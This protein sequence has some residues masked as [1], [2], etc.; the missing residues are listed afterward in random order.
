MPKNIYEIKNNNKYKYEIQLLASC[1]SELNLITIELQNYSYNIKTKLINRDIYFNYFNTLGDEYLITGLKGVFVLNEDKNYHRVNKVLETNYINGI[2]ITEKIFAFISN[3]LLPKGEN[4]LLIY[5]FKKNGTIKEINNYPFKI[6]NNSLYS[7]N[8][9]TINSIDI[10]RK[11]LFSSCVSTDKNGFLFVD[12][13]LK[14]NTF[15]ESFYE[16]K[17]FEPNCFCQISIVDNNN[18]INDD[19]AKEKN[20]EIKETEY[21]LVGGFEPIKRM[22]SVKLYKIKY[23]SKNDKINIRYLFDIATEDVDQFKG[24]NTDVTC[25]TQSKITGNLLI[26]CLDGNTYLFKPPNLEI[27]L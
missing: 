12:I 9:K 13:N 25:I 27:F 4:K 10:D 20:I 17:E 16:T 22:G 8:L 15:V 5:N 7:I 6:S 26:S 21:F 14:K 18:S 19:I 2:N 3:D 23:C 11:I 24:F 1:G